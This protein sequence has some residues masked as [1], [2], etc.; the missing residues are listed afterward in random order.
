MPRSCLPWG[1]GVV[2]LSSLS[3]SRHTQMG[4]CPGCSLSS[5]QP[6]EPAVSPK[7]SCSFCHTQRYLCSHTS[8][9]PPKKSRVC[10][11]MS[12]LKR[13]LLGYP[14]L[15]RTGKSQSS[16]QLLALSEPHMLS[17]AREMLSSQD[18]PV[19]IDRAWSPYPDLPH[20][21]GRQRLDAH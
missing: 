7:C 4:C 17:K 3:R 11:C 15:A 21:K 20:S 1:G 6:A 14:L 12:L 16:Q 13:V 5:R 8:I 18:T 2:M 9:L 19:L 10:L